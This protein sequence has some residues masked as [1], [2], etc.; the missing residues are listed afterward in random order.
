MRKKIIIVAS[1]IALATP[2]PA[3]AFGEAVNGF[4]ALDHC[5]AEDSHAFLNLFRMNIWIRCGWF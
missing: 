3:M 1:A 5:V 4:K 2:G